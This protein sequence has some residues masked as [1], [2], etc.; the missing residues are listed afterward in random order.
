MEWMLAVRLT[1]FA[2]FGIL[3]YLLVFLVCAGIV[4][5]FTVWLYRVGIKKNSAPSS[6]AW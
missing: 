4:V 1:A 5:A 3:P 6:K 2:L